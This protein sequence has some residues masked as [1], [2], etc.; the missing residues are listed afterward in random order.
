V[1]APALIKG[2][3][4]VRWL[5]HLT[6]FSRSAAMSEVREKCGPAGYGAFWMI[7]ERI[8]ENFEGISR[9]SEP[10]LCISEKE[11]RN[12]CG[13][14][15]K[16]LHD[17]LKILHNHGVIFTKNADSR[18]CLEAPILL[19][20]QDE[21]TRKARK[22][23]GI[24]P[25]PCRNNSGLQQTAEQNKAEERKN[26]RTG[27]KSGIGNALHAV[28]ERHG[29]LSEPERVRRI[30]RHIER[31]APRNPGGY[32]E[33]I[34]QKKPDFDPWEEAETTN[35]PDRQGPMAAGEILRQ[36]GYG[37]RGQVGP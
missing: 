25:E 10:E 21:S 2:D 27:E 19:Q 12:S 34:L 31:K 13:L 17:L 35:R 15:A 37:S 36:A 32:L 22:N 23:S 8:E 26:N 7:F 18:L 1:I 5:K 3:S 28:F 4:K 33:S 9:K 20:L 11:W 29:L 24:V 6:N 16:K 14:S 30:I